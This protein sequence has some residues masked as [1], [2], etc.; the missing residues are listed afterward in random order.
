MNQSQNS[1]STTNSDPREKVK[2]CCRKLIAFMCTQVGVGGLIVS[3]ALFGAVS[4]SSIETQ[5]ENIEFILVNNLHN[6]TAFKLWNVLVEFNTFNQTLTKSQIDRLLIKLQHSLVQAY[7]R[8]YDGR[9][10][11]EIWSFP[12][13]LMFSLSV[14]TMIG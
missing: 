13:A 6:E 3:Y 5:E 4:F 7:K 9:S 12:A 10:V 14:F 2:D 11:H 1:T 8:G